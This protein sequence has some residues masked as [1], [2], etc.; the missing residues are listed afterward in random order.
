MWVGLVS[1]GQSYANDKDT[2]R[3]PIFGIALLYPYTL[4]DRSTKFDIG[5]VGLFSGR[6][7]RSSTKGEE[8]YRSQFSVF[9]IYDYTLNKI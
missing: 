1:V 5:E 7:S 4:F 3:S 2:H 8:V 6:Q 9:P